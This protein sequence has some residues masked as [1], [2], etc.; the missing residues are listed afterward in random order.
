MLRRAAHTAV[1]LIPDVP[2]TTTIAGLGPVRI[3]LRRN[4]WFL[5]ERF[6]QYDGPI[7]SAFAT[8]IRPG[9]V[10]W[11]VGANIGVYTR[12]IKQWFHAGAVIA[13]EPMSENFALL[14]E[15]IRLSGASDITALQIAL[16]DRSGEETLQIDDVTSGTAVLDSIAGGEASQGRRSVGLPPRSESVRV[17]TVDELVASGEVPPPAVMKID[18][19]GAEVKVLAGALRTLRDHRPR[20]AIALHGTDKAEGTIRLLNEAGYTCAGDTK[21]ADGTRVWRELRA[22]DAARVGNNNIVAAFEGDLVLTRPP[23]WTVPGTPPAPASKTPAPRPT[24]N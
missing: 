9:D 8:F 3:R 14:T 18:T 5:W 13:V 16:A 19:E 21:A 24:G 12:V 15:N 22:E 17:R 2:W 6:G 11:D 20:L 7:L 10:V 23:K 4:R 1:R